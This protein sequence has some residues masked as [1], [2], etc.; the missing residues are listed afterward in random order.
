VETPEQLLQEIRADPWKFVAGAFGERPAFEKQRLILESIRDCQETLVP[1]CHDSSKTFTAAR[2]LM[3]FLFAHPGDAIV[4]STAPTFTQVAE[5]LWREVKV[6]YSKASFNLGGKLLN[7]KYELGPKWFAL[8][9]TSD[10]PVNYQG[11]HAGNILVILDEADGVKKEVWDAL[12]GTL[13]SGNAKL[14]AIGNPLDPTSEFAKRVRNATYPKSRVIRITADDVL[15]VSDKFPFLLQRKWVDDKRRV[16]GENSSLYKG[17]VLAQ[18]P[19]QSIDT[20]IPIPW[21]VQARNRSVE[22]GILTYGVDVARFG[23]NRTVR[24]LIAGNQLLWSKATSREDTVETA[25]RVYSDIV[26]YE[27][28]M[29]QIDVTGVGG[30]VMDQVRKQLPLAPIIGVHNGGQAHNT[31]K[32]VNR[33]AEMWWALREAFEND[34]IGLNSEDTD[35]IEELI[36]DLNRPTYSYNRRQQ[37]I[38][39]KYGLPRGTSEYGLDDEE[40]AAASPDRGDSFVLAW[41]AAKPFIQLGQTKLTRSKSYY[42][43]TGG[44][45]V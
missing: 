44:V 38:V 39:D 8:G 13:T 24:T 17:K 1:A 10:D 15:A 34:R 12:E 37:L 30:G 14:L 20:L 36:N 33:A 29:T 31:T 28:A 22:R 43:I 25:T 18:W 26:R 21:L 4:L 3:W 6:A 32:Y 40:R 11:F 23:S 5:L 7:T 35:A 9:I 41:T 16:W 27:P 42:P 2:A 19:D 45:R